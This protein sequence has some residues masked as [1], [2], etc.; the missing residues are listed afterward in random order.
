M[1][2]FDSEKFLFQS[3]PKYFAFVVGYYYDG[4]SQISWLDTTKPINIYKCV[5][6]FV[7]FLRIGNLPL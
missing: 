2:L 6:E 4:I 1:E 3:V 7:D 5:A